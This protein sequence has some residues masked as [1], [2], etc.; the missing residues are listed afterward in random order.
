MPALQKF[1]RGPRTKNTSSWPSDAS[2]VSQGKQIAMGFA[3]PPGKV[4]SKSTGRPT[5]VRLSQ[6]IKPAKVPK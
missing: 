6:R 1:N 2:A 4:I 3:P 5:R